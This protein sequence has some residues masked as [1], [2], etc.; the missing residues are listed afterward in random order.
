MRLAHPLCCAEVEIHQ[1]AKR[2]DRPRTDT[3]DGINTSNHVSKTSSDT[4]SDVHKL[5]LLKDFNETLFSSGNVFPDGRSRTSSTNSSQSGEDGPEGSSVDNAT[6][7][8]LIP[9]S[10]KRMKPRSKSKSKFYTPSPSSSMDGLD[11]FSDLGSSEGNMGSLGSPEG[12]VGSLRSPDGNVVFSIGSPD[13][14]TVPYMDDSSTPVS[15]NTVHMGSLQGN[16]VYTGSRDCS[17]VHSRNRGYTTNKD[18]KGRLRPPGDNEGRSSTGGAIA[19]TIAE[20]RIPVDSIHE[21]FAVDNIGQ[22]TNFQDSEGNIKKTNS[23]QCKANTAQV[24]ECEQTELNCENVSTNNADTEVEHV[25]NKQPTSNLSH[26]DLLNGS[27]ESNTQ[28]NQLSDNQLPDQETSGDTGLT[29]V[30][31]PNSVEV[32]ERT[33]STDRYSDLIVGSH[34]NN[35]VRNVNQDSQT[36]GTNPPDSATDILTPNNSMTEVATRQGGGPVPLSRIKCLVSMTTPR[37]M[38]LCGTTSLPGFVEF[39]MS[40]DGFGCLY[41]PSISPHVPQGKGRK[42]C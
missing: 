5:S 10:M 1:V 20:G 18:D 27:R 2:E 32:R 6:K 4:S 19:G 12:N 35:L 41:F 38:H 25:I 14:N 29:S 40:L 31:T 13:S 36:D 3:A 16:V 21:G 22:K 17:M 11:D 24:S 28:P 42:F 9:K 15:L 8:R 30:S 7:S 37:D 34:T 26:V 39:N 33:P 23:N